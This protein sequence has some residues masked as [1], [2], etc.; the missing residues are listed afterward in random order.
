MDGR[1]ARTVKRAGIKSA[2]LARGRTIPI[3]AST[4]IKLMKAAFED[5]DSDVPCSRRKRYDDFDFGYAADRAQGAGLAMG[6]GRPSDREFRLPARP[7]QRWLY[8]AV[9]R[10]SRA[11]DGECADQQFMVE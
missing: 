4:K 10:A 5:P 1:R 8:T 11:A 7:R 3:A 6:R 9:T 2:G